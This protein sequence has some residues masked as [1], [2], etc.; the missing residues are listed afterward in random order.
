MPPFDSHARLRSR[1]LAWLFV[2]L[3][4][5]LVLMA[6]RYTK[7]P[8][9][10]PTPNSEA[11]QWFWVAPV[12]APPTPRLPRLAA[13]KTPSISDS[14]PREVARHTAPRAPDPSMTMIAPTT[15]APATSAP[16]PAPPATDTDDPFLKHDRSAA[17]IAAQARRDVGKIDSDLRRESPSQIHAPANTPQTR[18]IAGLHAAKVQHWNDPV[19]IEEIPDEG[20]NGKRMAKVKTAFGTYCTTHD[21]NRSAVDGFEPNKRGPKITNCPR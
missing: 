2:I 10:P 6:W 11:T 18:L 16:A 19:E 4:H 20:G 15:S 9:R 5:I 21:S 3:I 17:D 14:A 12:K 7:A 13:R 1:S 8:Q